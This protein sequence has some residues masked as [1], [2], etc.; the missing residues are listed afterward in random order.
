MKGVAAPHPT[1]RHR[2]A[3]A[4]AVTAMA[5]PPLPSAICGG[6]SPSAGSDASPMRPDPTIDSHRRPAIFI[7]SWEDGLDPDTPQITNTM[8]GCLGVTHPHVAPPM[9]LYLPPTMR[10]AKRWGTV[11]RR[12]EQKRKREAKETP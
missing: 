4:D 3:P 10:A 11:A 9:V 2:R 6:G 5:V 1:R 8:R 7:R 12:S